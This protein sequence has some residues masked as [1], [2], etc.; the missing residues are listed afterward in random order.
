MPEMAQGETGT[1]E[2]TASGRPYVQLIT[3]RPVERFLQRFFLSS[4]R[5]DSM[6][7]VSPIIGALRGTRYR[8][9]Q[10]VAKVRAERIRTYVITTPPAEDD[11]YHRE[12]LDILAGCDWVEIRYNSSLHAKLYVCKHQDR[13]FGLLGSAN[14]T[15]TSVLRNTEVGVLV[16]S[17]GPGQGLVHEMYEWGTVRLRTSPDTK[18]VKRIS[19]PRR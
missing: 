10:V 13:G 3:E 16:S 17:R 7:L 8:L 2:G 6:L 11:R 5:F 14:L 1:T 4:L 19:A 9:E 18:L 15:P 12:A